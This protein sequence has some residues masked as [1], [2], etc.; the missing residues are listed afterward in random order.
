MFDKRKKKRVSL[1]ELL[2]HPICFCRP[3]SNHP[4]FSLFGV[5]DRCS[6]D[7]FSFCF[8]V[9]VV[10]VVVVPLDDSCAVIRMSVKRLICH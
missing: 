4:H 2:L 1:A 8:V 6:C 9:V 7:T 3:H 5:P 10:V